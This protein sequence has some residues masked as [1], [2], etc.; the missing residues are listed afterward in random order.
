[1][2]QLSDSEDSNIRDVNR[3]EQNNESQSE[4]KVKM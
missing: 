1:M 2:P 4:P 3:H